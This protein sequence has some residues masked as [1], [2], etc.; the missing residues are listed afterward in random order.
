MTRPHGYARYRLDGCRCY[1]CGWAVAQYNDARE[2]AMRR[3]TWQPWTDAEPVRVH[4]RNLQSCGM[5][6]RTVA[7]AS[8]VDRK[9][10]QA[11]LS[12][13][14]E[15]GTGPQEKVRP[16]LAAAVLAVEPTLE[17]LA[18][19]T[20]ISPLG[21]RRRAHALVA[22]GWPQ[23]YLA[24]RLGMTD[25]NYGAML[26]RDHVLVRRALAV[27]AF[28]DEL[29]NVDPTE[30]GATAAGIARARQRA[31]TNGWAPVGAWDD[32]TIDDPEA[33][34]D[35]TGKCGTPEGFWSHRYIKVPACQ[36]CRDAF[37]ADQRERGAQRNA[38]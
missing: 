27:R 22:V 29:W 4:L 34:P 20:L 6:L 1:V 26:R 9:R 14:P 2:H 8:N 23:H 21:T 38:S 35:W 13:R 3:G 10:L 31:A 24:A 25:S 15:R 5:G 16:E 19:N 33:F 12:G 30:H 7:A 36:P 37:N 32:D 28:Y 11:I 17:N 18:P